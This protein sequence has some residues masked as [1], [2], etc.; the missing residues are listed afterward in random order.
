[1]F[2]VDLGNDRRF[3]ARERIVGDKPLFGR[4]PNTEEGRSQISNWAMT[5][6]VAAVRAKLPFDPARAIVPVTKHLSVIARGD[7]LL[8]WREMAARYP[9]SAVQVVDG[10]DHALSDFDDHLPLL[11]RFL[12][13]LRATLHRVR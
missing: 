6:F 3:L 11:L 1:M 2:E 13:G 12:R 9:G 8:D 4:I 7:E 5:Q 10:S